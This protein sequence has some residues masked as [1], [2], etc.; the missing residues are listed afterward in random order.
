MEKHLGRRPP[1]TVLYVKKHFV[2]AQRHHSKPNFVPK[3]KATSKTHIEKCI[4]PR[5]NH[6]QSEKVIRPRF[7]SVEK[8]EAV[9]GVQSS[10]DSPFMV[11][12]GCYNYLYKMFNPPSIC[13]SC[14]AFPKAGTRFFRHSPDAIVVSQHLQSIT[15]SD[16]RILPTDVICNSCYKLHLTLTHA[17]DQEPESTLECDIPK[18]RAQVDENTNTLTKA[19]LTAVLYVAERLLQNKALLLPEVSRVFL[20]VYGV[21]HFDS[22]KS[23]DLTLEVGNST[24]K[25]SSRWVLSQL[26]IYLN[27]YMQYKCVHMKFGTESKAIY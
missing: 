5:C 17:R 6:S 20:E 15:G 2:E 23:L 4:N 7:E 25:F 18:W 12:Q 27:P 22:I 8:L 21:T 14:G 10:E 16:V 13:A 26:I 3:W 1:L 9:L 19:V 11:C 24:V